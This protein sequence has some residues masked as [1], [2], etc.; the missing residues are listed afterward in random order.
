MF[1]WEENFAF[2]APNCIISLSYCMYLVKKL[3]IF[4]KVWTFICRYK[5]LMI[6]GEK[7]FGP[8]PLPS[9]SFLFLRYIGLPHYNSAAEKHIERN[10]FSPFWLFAKISHMYQNL[11]IRFS[12]IKYHEQRSRT[13][14]CQRHNGPEGWVHITSS[15]TNLDHNSSSESRTGIKLK[16]TTKHE[17]LD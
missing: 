3:H 8:F 2:Y 16:I 5:Y 13:K 14:H 1:K 11:R 9:V 10:L 17:Y 6:E 15:Y 4:F 7:Q 12:T